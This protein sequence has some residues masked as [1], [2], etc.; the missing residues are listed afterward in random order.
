[1][2][3]LGGMHVGANQLFGNMGM[4]FQVVFQVNC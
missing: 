1:M 4:M 3:V 2:I